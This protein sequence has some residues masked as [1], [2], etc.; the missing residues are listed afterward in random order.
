[1]KNSL[2]KD[3]TDGNPIN[4]DP[5]DDKTTESLNSEEA[6]L[7]TDSNADDSQDGHDR[8]EDEDS[9]VDDA[10]RGR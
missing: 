3:I 9:A 7:P 2:N 5:G 6:V 8:S 4:A 1:M 10:T